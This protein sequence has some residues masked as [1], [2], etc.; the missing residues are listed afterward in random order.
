MLA[1]ISGTARPAR[2]SSSRSL[3]TAACFALMGLF[4]AHPS[5]LVP[6]A[7][8]QAIP[9]LGQAKRQSRPFIPLFMEETMQGH[10]DD[11]D[12]PAIGESPKRAEQKSF[13]CQPFK[14]GQ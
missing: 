2:R 11:G 6:V 14:A 12:K 13:W 8:N 3:E 4:P 1:S 7:S 10:E 9:H 5:N